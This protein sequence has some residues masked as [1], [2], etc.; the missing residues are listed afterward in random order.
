MISHG[1]YEKSWGVVQHFVGSQCTKKSFVW[2]DHIYSANS[3][4]IVQN[5]LL[6]AI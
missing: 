5:L 4:T 3:G 6:I 2:N 1:L